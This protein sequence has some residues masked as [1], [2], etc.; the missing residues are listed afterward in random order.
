MN[1]SKRHAL[2]RFQQLQYGFTASIRDPDRQPAPAEVDPRRMAVYQRLVYNNVEAY[3]ARA[4]ATVR[5]FYDDAGWHAMVRDFFVRHRCR[6]PQFFQ[7][8]EEFLQYFQEQRGT[9]AGDPPFLLELAHL[10]WLEMMLYVVDETPDLTGVDRGG[11]LLDGAP[12]LS[13]LA[14]PLVY[15]YPVHEIRPGIPPEEPAASTHLIAY[16]ELTGAEKVRFLRI[17]AVTARLLALIEEHPTR[18]GSDQLRAIAREM[19]HADPDVVL[20]GGLQTL[21]D[22]HDRDIV[23][24]VRATGTQPGNTDRGEADSLPRSRQRIRSG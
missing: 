9:R 17:N 15:R 3:L 24:G 13:P 20:S 21:T 10:A 16:R 12:V 2:P 5:S 11:D 1:D 6:R 7:V 18:S 14:Q 4:F 22:L 19:G 23:L 8:A